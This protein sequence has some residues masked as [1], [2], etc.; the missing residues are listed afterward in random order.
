MK[1]VLEN[2][3]KWYNRGA[4]NEVHAV[5]S[6]SLGIRENEVVCIKGPSGS[7]KSSLLGIIGCLFSPTS[8]LATIDGKKLSRLPDRFLT[9][10]RRESIGFIFQRLRTKADSR[11]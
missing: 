9:N 10:L 1:I 8:G 7:G 5:R 2:V 11:G 6:V 4:L 3:D